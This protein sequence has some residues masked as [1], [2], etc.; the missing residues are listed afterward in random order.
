MLPKVEKILTSTI[1][2][3]FTFEAHEFVTVKRFLIW[4]QLSK[5]IFHDPISL[6]PNTSRL[7][8]DL[9]CYLCHLTMCLLQD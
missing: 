6:N 2:A 9:Q 4:K 8:F 3:C 5:C 1:E 7:M